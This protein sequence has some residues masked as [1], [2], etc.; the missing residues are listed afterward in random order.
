ML[1]KFLLPNQEPKCV[2]DINFYDFMFLCWL[3]Y[4]IYLGYVL[5]STRQWEISF[6]FENSKSVFSAPFLNNPPS[7]HWLVPHYDLQNSLTSGS[8][9]GLYTPSTDLTNY[10]MLGTYQFNYCRF[11]VFFPCSN[12][13][14]QIFKT[15]PS[16]YIPYLTTLSHTQLPRFSLQPLSSLFQNSPIIFWFIFLCPLL[17]YL[18]LSRRLLFFQNLYQTPLP[19]SRLSSY[20]PMAFTLMTK[21]PDSPCESDSYLTA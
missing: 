16:K 7:S 2:S 13:G 17:S 5:A 21:I 19:Y 12:G 10:C 14:Q 4:L 11:V 1:N 20:F 6:C 9:W 3:N 15:V 8:L 18:G